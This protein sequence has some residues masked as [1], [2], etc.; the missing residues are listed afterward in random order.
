MF[1]LNLS[2]DN[3]I[4]SACKVLPDSNYNNMPIVYNLPDGDITDY[5]YINNEYIYDPI[6]DEDPIEHGPSLEE[7]VSILENKMDT[8]I[9]EYEESLLEL[10]VEL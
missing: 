1:A 2:L 6:P 10:G 5:L 8:K 3:R 7:R 4:L 9:T